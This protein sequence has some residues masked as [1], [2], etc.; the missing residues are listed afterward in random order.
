VT[1][2]VD[3]YCAWP[4]QACGYKV[5]HSEI[6]RL[7]AKAREALGARFDLRKFNDAVVMGGGVPMLTLA[8]AID[9]FIARS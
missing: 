4:G 3:R 1:G 9:S 5:G 2:E 8:R 7:R 6:N